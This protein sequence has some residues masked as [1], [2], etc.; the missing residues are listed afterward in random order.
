MPDMKRN[1]V[2]VILLSFIACS[3]HERD[4]VTTGELFFSPFRIGSYYNKPDSFRT[5]VESR[6][7]TI[8]LEKASKDIKIL[9]GIYNTV[10]N[11]KLA[12]KPFVDLRV[13]EDSYLKLYLDSADYDKIKKHKWNDLRD[14][15]KKVIIKARTREIGDTE[16]PLFY[17]VE[18][19]EV[20]VV[21]GE[22]LP[23]RSKFKI[24]DY[25]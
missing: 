23:G 8:N 17:C 11:A 15:G 10:K 5:W 20:N 24:E 13:D 21:P 9:Y 18:L 14:E 12:Y 16:F 2:F 6:I 1:C 3:S 22:T 4:N 25:E 19:L 7:D